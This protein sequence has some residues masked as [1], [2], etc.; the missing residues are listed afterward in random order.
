MISTANSN[1]D[2]IQIQSLDQMILAY[3][4]LVVQFKDILRQNET[5]HEQTS[6][7]VGA[8]LGSIM[9]TRE[10]MKITRG[11]FIELEEILP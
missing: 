11:F 2:S 10:S 9:A 3:D 6:A 1:N 5:L 4:Q 7:I 8:L